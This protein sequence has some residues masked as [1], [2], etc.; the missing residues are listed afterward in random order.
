[1]ILSFK[2]HVNSNYLEICMK[3]S[4]SIHFPLW[5]ERNILEKSKIDPTTE[6]NKTLDISVVALYRQNVYAY[7]ALRCGIKL[8]VWELSVKTSINKKIRNV[9]WM[10]ECVSV[11][12]RDTLFKWVNVATWSYSRVGKSIL[13]GF[14]FHSSRNANRSFDA[15]NTNAETIE[16]WGG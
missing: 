5:G 1:M 3:F 10:G 13:Q 14:I 2:I 16:K 6:S 4:S 15:A 11:Y 12:V 9:S 8:L 7:Q